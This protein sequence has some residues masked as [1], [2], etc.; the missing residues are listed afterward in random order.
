MSRSLNITFLSSAMPLI[1][2]SNNEQLRAEYIAA[3]N[4]PVIF[5]FYSE[6]NLTCDDVNPIFE[7]VAEEYSEQILALYVNYSCQ[8][9]VDGTDFTVEA[10]PTVIVGINGIESC[11][12]KLVESQ[13]TE[14]SLRALFQK[15]CN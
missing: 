1:P 5:Y 4:Y 11:E 13:I 2:V 12:D 14:E 6:C 7:Q 3:G 10:T 15:Y 8:S 9:L